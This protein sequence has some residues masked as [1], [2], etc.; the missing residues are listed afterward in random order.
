MTD[1]VI[2]QRYGEQHYLRSVI[3]HRW[4]PSSLSMETIP[5]TVI[6]DGQGKTSDLFL[7]KTTLKISFIIVNI[8]SQYFLVTPLPNK[9]V[10]SYE[11]PHSLLLLLC[12]FINFVLTKEIL[13]Q[14]LSDH[15]LLGNLFSCLD[16]PWSENFAAIFVELFRLS[17][18]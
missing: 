2:F 11:R 18:V 13:N 6:H 12:W 4:H 10:G 1:F 15:F 5:I 3:Y 9:N 16:Y 8:F 17:M 7:I 14:Y